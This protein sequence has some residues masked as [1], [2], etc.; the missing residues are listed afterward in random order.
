MKV[1]KSI[2]PTEIY[3]SPT[4]PGKK[5]IKR[6]KGAEIAFED[7]TSVHFGIIDY[8]VNMNALSTFLPIISDACNLD[9]FNGSTLLEIEFISE[10]VDGTL[11]FEKPKNK[12][13]EGCLYINIKTSKGNLKLLCKENF[14]DG[15]VLGSA[16][17]NAD[18]THDIKVTYKG[19]KGSNPFVRFLG[20][21]FGRG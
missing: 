21:L 8:L 9:E 6:N 15:F 14:P 10:T 11:D 3:Y 2:T 17:P 19:C 5:S 1:I 18:S 12:V 4:S 16:R 20:K 13:I 7:G